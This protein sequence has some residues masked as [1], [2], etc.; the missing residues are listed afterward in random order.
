[1]TD[2]FFAF[3]LLIFGLILFFDRKR[4]ARLAVEQQYR[5]FGFRFDDTFHRY[6]FAFMGLLFVVIGIT[7]LI[8]LK[9][10]GC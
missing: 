6:A 10:A 1:V 8:S 4:A 3:I 5:L 7:A 2:S 9:F